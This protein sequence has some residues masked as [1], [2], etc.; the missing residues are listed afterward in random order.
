MNK[1]HW[2]DSIS[3]ETIPDPVDS[4]GSCPVSH[5]GILQR[6][7]AHLEGPKISTCVSTL[8]ARAQLQERRIRRDRRRRH[9][10]G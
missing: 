1:Q 2:L 6:L 8:T 5:H 9:G 3:R 7:S 10:R 4:R